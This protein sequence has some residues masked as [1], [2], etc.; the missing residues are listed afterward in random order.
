MAPLA[1]AL[2]RKV[3]MTHVADVASALDAARERVGPGDARLVKGSNAV[4]LS[5]LVEALASEKV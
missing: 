5:A 3:K 2:G 4:G 1:K